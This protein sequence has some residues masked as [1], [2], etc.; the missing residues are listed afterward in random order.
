MVG[1]TARVAADVP[2]RAVE[3]QDEVGVGRSGS[4]EVVEED[5]H[6]GDVD[7]GQHEGDVLAGGGADRGEDVGPLVAELP[8]AGRALSAPPPAV[9]DPALVADPRLVFEPQRPIRLPG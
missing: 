1:G 2:A 9:A 4:G 5:L 8:D 7:R 6:R 3:H